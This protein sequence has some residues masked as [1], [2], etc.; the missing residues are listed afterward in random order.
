[1]VGRSRSGRRAVRIR[2][3]D[4]LGPSHRPRLGA[5]SNWSRQPGVHRGQLDLPSQPR[6]SLADRHGRELHHRV[7]GRHSPGPRAGV[8]TGNH[9]QRACARTIDDAAVWLRDGIRGGDPRDSGARPN[10][11]G[12]ECRHTHVSR[13]PEHS[14][15][16]GRGCVDDQHR[17]IPSGG[18]SCRLSIR[19]VDL[20]APIP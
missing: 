3:C 8:R 1:M 9:P 7:H 18:V 10:L 15:H 17:R 13:H 5:G 16:C 4:P 14:A 20:K 11:F 6:A 19:R 2:P 12:R